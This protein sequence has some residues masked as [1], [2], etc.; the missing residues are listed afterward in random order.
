MW[1]IALLWASMNTSP[2]VQFQLEQPFEL[3]MGASAHGPDQLVVRYDGLGPFIVPDTQVH[4]PVLGLG[5]QGNDYGQFEHMWPSPTSVGTADGASARGWW[6]QFEITVLSVEEKEPYRA[7]ISVSALRPHRRTLKWDTPFRFGRGELW[8]TPSGVE[9]ALVGGPGA[10]SYALEL[11]C[12]GSPYDFGLILRKDEVIARS[13]LLFAASKSPTSESLD[14][15]IW[16]P[17]E[18]IRPFTLDKPVRLWTGETAKHDDLSVRIANILLPPQIS[19]VEGM[20]R[21]QPPVV[22]VVVVERAGRSESLTLTD[23]A[24][25]ETADGT[26]SVTLT[27]LATPTQE[28]G[29]PMEFVELLIKRNGH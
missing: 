10:E 5:H 6:K 3:V 23:K 11:E 4:L 17:S 15:R 25:A 19:Y 24:T 16:R 20:D 21:T 13:D 22:Y 27:V 7:R 28:G 26:L 8:V 9:C 12:R 18:T 29:V 1:A 2:E 14:V